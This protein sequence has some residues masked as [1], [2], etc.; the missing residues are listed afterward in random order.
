MILQKAYLMVTILV[1]VSL[2]SPKSAIAQAQG[3]QDK[4]DVPS[5]LVPLLRTFSTRPPWTALSKV[6]K[7]DRGQLKDLYKQA[8]DLS[9]KRGLTWALSLV[10][11][12]ETVSLFKEV[13][14]KDYK[15]KWLSHH[16]EN[17]LVDTVLAMGLLAAKHDSARSFIQAGTDP[18]YWKTRKTWSSKRGEYSIDLLVSFSIQAIG[19]SGRSAG[20]DQEAGQQNDDVPELLDRFKSKDAN[21][22]HRF[23]G[24]IVQA[25][26]YHDIR[27]RRGDEFLRKYLLSKNDMA[28]WR[29]WIRTPGGKQWFDWANDRMRGPRPA[30]PASAE[31][32]DSKGK[33][34]GNGK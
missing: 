30:M 8:P 22:L 32:K 28:L 23:A 21:Y 14:Q 13:L 25:A 12:E 31:S 6:D 3:G 33:S 2:A 1:F 7:T 26:F 34:G 24:D 11:D 10:G 18:S 20:R 9:R 27:M 17:V 16:E 29:A 4:R 15:E 19:I 5:R